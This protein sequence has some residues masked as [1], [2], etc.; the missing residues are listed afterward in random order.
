MQS[1]EKTSK[2]FEVIALMLQCTTAMLPL[3]LQFM[4]L[5]FTC[6]TVKLFKHLLWHYFFHSLPT[7]RNGTFRG[8][9]FVPSTSTPACPVIFHHNKVHIYF[10]FV[11]SYLVVPQIDEGPMT[12]QN[13]CLTRNSSVHG[14]ATRLYLLYIPRQQK[15][16]MLYTFSYILRKSF[17]FFF[18]T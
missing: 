5:N 8:P 1:E 11:A 17:I 15:I 2:T 7:L 3:V 16:E 9:S 12:G 18:T 10:R 6:V 13:V 4:C 14:G